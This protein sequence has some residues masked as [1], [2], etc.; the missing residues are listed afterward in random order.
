MK[1]KSNIYISVF[2]F[3]WLNSIDA[4]TD[5]SFKL[6]FNK[7]MIMVKQNHPIIKQAQLLLKTADASTLAAYGNFDPK[8]FYD[9]DN[10]TFNA[11]N[12]YQISNGGFKIP[13]W[14][15]LEIKGG[16][17][18][19]NGVYLNP[20]RTT[21]YNGLIYTQLSLPLVQG[22]VID[23]RRA[24]LKQAKI[25]KEQSVFDQINILNDILYKAGKTYWDWYFS[26]LN[27]QIYQNAITLS[28]TRFDAVKQTLI[29]GDKSAI[30]SVEALIQLQDRRLNLQQ[31]L[32]DYNSKSLFLSN[33]IWLD[34]NTPL[35]ITDKTTPEENYFTNETSKT[36]EFKIS[37]LDSF[38]Y[39]HPNLKVY[40]F[41]L[42]QLDVEKRFKQ[43]KLKPNVLINY[44][45]L[46]SVSNLNYNSNN[47][48]WGVSFGYSLFL[49]KERADLQITKI[50]I[51]NVAYENLNKRNEL[52]NKIKATVYEFKS[53]QNQVEIYTKNVKNYEKLWESERRLFD[54]G[55]SSL[56]MINSRETSYINAQL[57]L[58]ELLNKNQQ[59]ILGIDFILG[60]LQSKY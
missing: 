50:K 22:L 29:L 48:K 44:S 12:Y 56:F 51:Q 55:E 15:G 30:D 4:Q 10:K 13:T 11:K 2:L 17:E 8:V 34:E 60:I 18:N 47:Y 7:F 5:T 24:T 49:R 31:A 23:E 25:F 53:Y 39:I 6:N 19:N 14:F 33:Y 58:N 41:K 16:I 9:L 28:E 35:E 1:L 27:V 52:T 3:F 43:E 59:S 32:L 57:K 37:K 20:E 21:P 54:S 38:I 26:Y 42:K 40:E 45:P 46:S 36:V